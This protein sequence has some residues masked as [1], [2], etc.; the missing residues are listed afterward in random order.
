MIGMSGSVNV[1]INGAV[2]GA[3]ELTWIKLI[4]GSFRFYYQC[5]NIFKTYALSECCIGSHRQTSIVTL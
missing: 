1:L 4:S 3:V 5:V 2:N